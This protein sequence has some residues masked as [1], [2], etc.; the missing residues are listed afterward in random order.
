M[1]VY[2]PWFGS[3]HGAVAAHT[4]GLCPRSS[5]DPLWRLKDVALRPVEHSAAMPIGSS[6]A[7]G[8]LESILIPT[9]FL[10]LILPAAPLP[11]IRELTLKKVTADKG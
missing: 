3:Q 5:P 6:R 8:G 10:H 2:L 7:I 1:F 4:M 11:Q 9:F